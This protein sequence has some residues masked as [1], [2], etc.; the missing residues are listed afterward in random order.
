MVLS[1]KPMS[2]IIHVEVA[3]A[4]SVPVPVHCI[5]NVEPDVFTCV[6]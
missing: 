2:I 5:D 4:A 3:G 1:T 6:I